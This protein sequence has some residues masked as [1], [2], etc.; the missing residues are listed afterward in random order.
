M[1]RETVADKAER[2]LLEGRIVLEEVTRH[3]I[4]ATVRG[5]GA[6][7]R[8][9]WAGVWSCTC[10]HQARSTDCSHIAACKRV[11]AVDLEAGR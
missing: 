5:E 6:R 3:G 4:T 11:V 2:Y 10:P 9:T 1:S 7:Y 8:T